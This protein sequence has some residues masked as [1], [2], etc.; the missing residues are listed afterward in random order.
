MYLCV[1]VCVCIYIYKNMVQN[2][3]KNGYYVTSCERGRVEN[4]NIHKNRHTH[5]TT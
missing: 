5:S 4:A 2:I 3:L 1:Y